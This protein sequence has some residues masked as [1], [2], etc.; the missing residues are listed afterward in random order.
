M[1]VI[2]SI[3]ILLTLG[4]YLD[5]ASTP[6]EVEASATTPEP[7]T[8]NA[9]ASSGLDLRIEP[10]PNFYFLVRAQATDVVPPES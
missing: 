3:L 4:L 10:F 8:S 6:P 1:K 9:V 7:A 2:R 5:C